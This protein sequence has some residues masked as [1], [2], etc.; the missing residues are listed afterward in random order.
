M[1]RC[2][3]CAA[4]PKGLEGHE[5]LTIKIDG[6]PLYGQAKGHHLFRCVVCTLVWE[7]HYAGGGAFHWRLQGD[8]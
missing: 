3:Q 4:G 6:Q 8:R 7:R 2:A 1:D 5:G